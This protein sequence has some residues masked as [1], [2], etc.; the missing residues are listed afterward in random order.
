MQKVL[1]GKYDNDQQTSNSAPF[2]LPDAG[3]GFLYFP[4]PDGVIEIPV[5]P[6]PT[7]EESRAATAM[8]YHN[9]RNKNGFNT[10][11]ALQQMLDAEEATTNQT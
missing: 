4:A 1:E 5:N 2:P 11:A 9:Y 3:Q 10:M 6:I 8:P 7:K